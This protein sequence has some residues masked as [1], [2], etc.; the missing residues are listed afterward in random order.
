MA[1]S[2]QLNAQP[3]D[4][5]RKGHARKLR[6]TG[7][8][9]AI[10]Y[11]HGE[12]TR[13]LSVDAAE[14]SRLLSSISVENTVIELQIE[15][16][17]QPVKALVREVQTHPYRAEVLHLDFYQIHAGERVQIEVPVRLIGQA[18]GVREG[19]ILDQ[20]LYDLQVRC[21]A[22][23]IPESIE[24]NVADLGIN[25]SIHVRDIQVP[26]GATVLNDGD[27]TICTLVPP[28][29]AAPTEPAEGAEPVAA[30]GAEPELIRKQRAAEEE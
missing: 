20:V 19:G 1:A 5:N 28:T 15:G 16:A 7:R 21:V 8:V 18:R 11:G 30:T 25:E 3:R 2:A 22:E 9:P 4:G 14:L 6:A 26:E 13:E 23:Q 10:L 29:V 24:V 27:Q 17:K 12:E